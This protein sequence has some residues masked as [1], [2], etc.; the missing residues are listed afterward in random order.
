MEYLLMKKAPQ[1]M[2][3]VTEHDII[4]L[5]EIGL[6]SYKEKRWQ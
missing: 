3:K 6:A 5:K 1:M 4:A 2:E